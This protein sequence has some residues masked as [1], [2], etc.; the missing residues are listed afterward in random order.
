MQSMKVANS[1][2]IYCSSPYRAEHYRGSTGNFDRVDHVYELDSYACLGNA[3]L[4]VICKF[5]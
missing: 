2:D 1:V 4:T 5:D 3:G